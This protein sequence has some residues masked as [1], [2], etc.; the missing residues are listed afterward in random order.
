MKRAGLIGVFISAALVHWASADP[1]THDVVFKVGA[2]SGI[3]WFEIDNPAV[4]GTIQV[5][6]APY[7]SNSEL[8][9]AV[10]DAARNRL[11]FVTQT[12]SA[13]YSID[14]TG[15]QLLQNGATVV[16][17][18]PLGIAPGLTTDA[19]YNKGNGQVYYRPEDTDELRYLNF[20]SVGTITGYTSVGTMQG[21]TQAPLTPFMQGGDL[22]FDASGSL[23]L[24][25]D[26]S[27][28]GPRVWNFDPT[29]LQLISVVTAPYEYRGMIF[30]AAGQTMYGYT[31][32]T[33]QYGIINPTTGQ[34]QTVLDT[35]V[36]SF[37]DGGDLAEATATIVP[38]P[39][40]LPPIL[41][42]GLIA[43]RRRRR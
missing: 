15:L 16:N 28:G 29:T 18:T 7:A 9:G 3:E 41:L 40:F 11:I 30:D 39:F 38:E 25:G 27:T 35:D 22:D 2:N 19:G 34:F 8:N 43:V 32:S 10:V 6:N 13:A 33:S 23:W 21:T 14:L 12:S 26:N 4:A 1:I 36:N 24:T 37:G 5:A 31:D 17:V 42:V 20:D